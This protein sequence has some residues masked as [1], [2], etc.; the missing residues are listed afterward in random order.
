MQRIICLFCL[1]GF[2]SSNVTYGYGEKIASKQQPP[3]QIQPQAHLQPKDLAAGVIQIPDGKVLVDRKDFEELKNEIKETMK[4]TVNHF[5][6]EIILDDKFVNKIQN[7][8][9]QKI[10]KI[11]SGL[12]FYNGD[13]LKDINGLIKNPNSNLFSELPNLNGASYQCIMSIWAITYAYD[14]TSIFAFSN[15]QYSIYPQLKLRLEYSLKI[16]NES[17]KNLSKITAQSKNTALQ[18]KFLNIINKIREAKEIMEELKT[19]I[20]VRYETARKAKGLKK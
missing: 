7:N 15:N 1:V 9:W 5:E 6:E 11:R 19:E 10:D 20:D 16:F 2:L 8:Y 3:V 4:K 12:G 13:L 14:L 18:S 17:I